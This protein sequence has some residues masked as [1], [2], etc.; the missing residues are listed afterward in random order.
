MGRTG[1]RLAW[2][3]AD[4]NRAQALEEKDPSDSGI[5]ATKNTNSIEI[6]PGR[7]EFLSRHVPATLTHPCTIDCT[8]RSQGENYL[9]T[10]M[11][12][13]IRPNESHNG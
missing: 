1:N 8:V 5:T 6:I 2:I 10:G 11:P 13:S 3:L 9:D 4:T 7:C 12:K